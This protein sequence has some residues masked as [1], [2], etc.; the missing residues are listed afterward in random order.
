[1]K[2]IVSLTGAALLL[3]SGCTAEEV[4]RE[5]E[6]VPV[7]AQRPQI[8][9]EQL[10]V[11]A[12]GSARAETSAEIYPQA[13]GLVRAVRFSANDFVRAGAPLVELDSRRERLAVDLAQVQ[14]EEASQLL[15]RYRRIEDTGA[16]SQ[17]QIEAGETALASARIAL[18]QA[19]TELADRTVRAPFS[20]HI[21][22][23][24][25]DPGDRIGPDTL[26]AQ[27]DRRSTLFVDFPA[28]E[29]AFSRLGPG[30]VVSVIPFSN[31]DRQIDA[32]V[33]AVDSG[34]SAE[35]RTYTVRTAID[36]SSD[37]LR[38]GMSFR[39]NFTSPGVPRPALPEEAVVWGGEGAYLWLVQGGKAVRTPVTIASR[40]E[41]LA[42]VNGKLGPRD[43]VIVE[44]VQK[45]REGQQVDLV[46]P[47]GVPPRE[48]RLRRSAASGATAR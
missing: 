41:G 8:L 20:G 14:V 40:R 44:G 26:I 37:Q 35:R 21:G 9:P 48:V 23:T 31:P 28:P 39:V 33:I 29:T 6:A 15:A 17:S 38:P 3:F 1:M 30:Q 19:R 47:A 4:E 42:L 16:I 27:L 10:Q 5:P 25:V 11:Q 45:V 22:L 43:L 24:E 7:V 36:N 12:V 18:E 34:V 13:A 32:R 46:Q 2:A